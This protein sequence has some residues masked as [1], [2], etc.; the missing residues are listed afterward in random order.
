MQRPY[1]SSNAAPAIE[2]V[3][4]AQFTLLFLISLLVTAG[5]VQGPREE[6]RYTV[7]DSGVLSLS[8]GECTVSEEDVTQVSNISVSRVILHTGSGDVYGLLAAP[9]DPVAGFVLAP[10][11]GVRKEMHYNRS[12]TYARAGYAFLVLDLR[13]NG[14]DT[15]GYPFSIDRDFQSFM[16]GEWPQYYLSICDLIH[17]GEY[18]KER[19]GIPVYAAGSSNGGRYA[20]I[21]TA[22]DPVFSGYIGVSTSGFGLAG[23][24]YS[25]DARHFLLS[26]D[27]DL[28]MGMISPKSSW[29]FHSRSDEIIPFEEGRE[30]YNLTGEP[31]IFYSFTGSHGLCGEVDEK[32]IG[33]CAQIYGVRS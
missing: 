11:A 28:Y 14:G 12:M 9:D 23:N 15:A 33:E 13:G 10:G 5:C 26:I 6:A 21:A 20:A 19:Y 31:R 18:V 1:V 32:I 22:L 30:L 17:A 3:K 16:E 24:R 29:I 4:P 27:P 8:C 25:G 2:M 7:S